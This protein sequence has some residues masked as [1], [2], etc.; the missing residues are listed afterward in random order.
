MAFRSIETLARDVLAKLEIDGTATRGSNVRASGR[1]TAVK[2]N[3][4]DLLPPNIIE[5]GVVAPSRDCGGIVGEP[6]IG[7]V[8]EITKMDAST[9]SLDRSSPAP[10][11]GRPRNALE[12]AGKSEPLGAVGTI[13]SA[14]GEAEIAPAVIARVAIDMV[15]E[16]RPISSLESPDQSVLQVLS[17]KD[18]DRA[19]ASDRIRTSSTPPV[20][21]RGAGVR[22]PKQM[23]G[24]GVVPENGLELVL[25]QHNSTPAVKGVARPAG[26]RGGLIAERAFAQG[27]EVAA[28]QTELGKGT[29]SEPAAKFTGEEPQTKAISRNWM[30]IS[31]SLRTIRRNKC[32]AAPQGSPTL[33]AHLFLVIGHASHPH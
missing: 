11:G 6:G 20:H 8:A 25:A 4:H 27:G 15:D 28:E 14:V 12:P 24:V 1:S 21:V 5:G 29:A 2:K 31:A 26:V 18:P 22:D 19:P 17:L 9:V 33:A 16:F 10:I 32:A 23:A 13:L 30:A 7:L 3:V